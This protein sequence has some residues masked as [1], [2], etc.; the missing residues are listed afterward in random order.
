[1]GDR[2]AALPSAFSDSLVQFFHREINVIP[3]RAR[4]TYAAWKWGTAAE[5]PEL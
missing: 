1:M 2:G 3:L 5:R 4:D